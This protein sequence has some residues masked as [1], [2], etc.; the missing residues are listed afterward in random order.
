MR[1]DF[2]KAVECLKL[3]MDGMSIRACE[4]HVGI[5]RDTICDLILKIGERCRDFLNTRL[6]GVPVADVQSARP[7]VLFP[8]P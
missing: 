3:L 7:K 2:N 1:V 6:Q 8:K 5:H 4:R